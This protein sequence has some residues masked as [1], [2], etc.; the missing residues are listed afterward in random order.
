CGANK[1]GTAVASS[2]SSA[3]IVSGSED[4]LEEILLRVPARQLIQLKLVSKKW[5]AFISGPEFCRRHSRRNAFPKASGVSM[6][7]RRTEIV[8][9]SL[10]GKTHTSTSHSLDFVNY[11]PGLR[12]LQS[13]NGLL[14][15]SSLFIVG[16][17]C[18][19][20]VC[21]PTTGRF[22]M[23]PPL[24]TAESDTVLGANLAFDPRK[25]PHYA[26]VCV[27]RS[28]SLVYRYEIEIY[29]SEIGNWSVCE[30]PCVAPYYMFFDDAFF[31]NGALHWISLLGESIRFDVERR[32]LAKMRQVHTRG[33]H[34]RGKRRYNFFGNPHGPLHLIEIHG[35]RVTKFNIFLMEGDYAS[36][37]FKYQGDY[38]RSHCWLS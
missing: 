15:C 5:L 4:L 11:P 10:T 20:Y 3:E 6:R 38:P 32:S 14:L 37:V 27:R 1:R 30:S 22:S 28:S 25:S 19:Y 7:R 8:F 9:I 21:N 26:V 18:D 36:W 35:V 31:W 2:V 16:S 24:L 17:T 29:S 12:I 33:T 13:C 34:S 23:L